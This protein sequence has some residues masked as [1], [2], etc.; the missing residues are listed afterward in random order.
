MKSTKK[1][2][3]NQMSRTGYICQRNW[4]H[5]IHKICNEC[6]NYV[7]NANSFL[8]LNLSNEKKNMNSKSKHI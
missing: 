5:K 4:W 7:T 1:N 3:R 8:G 6:P 2:V